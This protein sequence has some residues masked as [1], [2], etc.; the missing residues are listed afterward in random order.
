MAVI[1]APVV[2]RAVRAF[3]TAAR[4]NNSCQHK[5]CQKEFKEF[6]NKKID[7]RIGLGSHTQMLIEHFGKQYAPIFSLGF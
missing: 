5:D 3:S 6:H 2:L 1:Y 7:I 4:R